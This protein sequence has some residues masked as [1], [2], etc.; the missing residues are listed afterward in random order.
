MA[1]HVIALAN[2]KGGCGKTTL[3]INL[4]S[5]LARRGEV[6]L[7]D[8]DPQGALRHWSGWGEAKSGLPRLFDDHDDAHA[9]LAA[10]R[11][12]CDYVIV[13]CPPS[14]DMNVTIE[15]LLH[16]H[17]VLIPVLPS[18]LDLWASAD[19]VKAVSKARENGNETL[20]AALLLNQTEPR[21]AM[22]RAM[23]NAITGLGLPVLPAAVRRRAAYRTAVVEG[24]SV[25]Q[26]G[27]RGRAAVDEI[28]NIIDEVTSS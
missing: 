5:G 3:S 21:S 1:A 26:L 11:E 9:N 10:A 16:S 18:P 6:G 17:R 24:V 27:G 20:V 15:L 19:T 23:Q 13:D 22:S 25:Y 7:I 14:L 12:S 4:A 28:E 8:A 2:L